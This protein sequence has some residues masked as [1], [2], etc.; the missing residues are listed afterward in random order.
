MRKAHEVVA[1]H[2]VSIN[3]MKTK[4]FVKKYIVITGTTSR[5]VSLVP[6]ED[7]TEILEAKELQNYEVI[8]EDENERS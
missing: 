8:V 2:S 4:F 7:G 6:V 3:E 5:A 1:L